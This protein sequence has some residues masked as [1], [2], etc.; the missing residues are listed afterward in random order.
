MASVSETFLV[1][2]FCQL[3]D[4]PIGEKWHI[5]QIMKKGDQ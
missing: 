3:E 4:I 5:G 2:V 1:L